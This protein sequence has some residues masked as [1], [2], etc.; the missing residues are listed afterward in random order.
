M[1]NKF[2]WHFQKISEIKD[3]FDVKEV[4]EFHRVC[5]DS[6]GI[7]TDWDSDNKRKFSE[8]TLLGKLL[9]QTEELCGIA[10]YSVPEKELENS[11]LLWENGIC[12]VKKAQHLG[13]SSIAI[14]EAKQL[15]SERKFGWFGGKSQNPKIFLRYQ[16]LGKTF[17]FEQLYATPEGQTL[18][19]FLVE[20]IEELKDL[21]ESGK[22]NLSSGICTAAYSRYLGDYS[23]SLK[24]AE[25]FENHLKKLGFNRT[26]GDSVVVIAKLENITHST[27]KEA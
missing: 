11:Y 20:N 24:G 14:E 12:I 1:L 21:R 27:D 25:S 4:K 17:P 18:M 15:F 2:T 7:E 16:N 22:L 26:G 5:V 3:S 6:F 9:Y 23:I 19:T 13:L 10:Y 8:S